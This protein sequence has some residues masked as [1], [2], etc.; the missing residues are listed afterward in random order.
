MK[1]GC[2]SELK[3]IFY[4]H[5]EVS[6]S[7]KRPGQKTEL[8]RKGATEKKENIVRSKLFSGAQNPTPLRPPDTGGII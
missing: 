6:C 7:A 5:N 1:T 3:I 8:L 4:H 2:G